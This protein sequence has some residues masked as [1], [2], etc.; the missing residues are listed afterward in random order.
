ME[1]DQDSAVCT[2]DELLAPDCG[3]AKGGTAKQVGKSTDGMDTVAEQIPIDSQAII[4]VPTDW[5]C[6]VSSC[7]VTCLKFGKVTKGKG[8][9]RT[10]S[11]Y[12]RI[13]ATVPTVITS[14][15]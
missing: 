7:T 14:A 10:R 13:P 4:Q 12:S 1:R 11:H 6:I 3:Y 2:S 8:A 5:H 9:L 15:S